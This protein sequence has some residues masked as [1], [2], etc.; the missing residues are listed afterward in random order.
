MISGGTGRFFAALLIN[1]TTLIRRSSEIPPPKSRTLESPDK[2]L[3]KS[4]ET[5]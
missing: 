4:D 1:I 5:D 2:D 3:I